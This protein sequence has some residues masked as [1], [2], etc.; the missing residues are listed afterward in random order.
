[1]KTAETA[2]KK[3]ELREKFLQYARAH[4]SGERIPTMAEFRKALGVTNYMLSG[5]MN[6]LVR[7]GF[8]VRKSR[9][10]GTFLSVAPKGKVIGLILEDGASNEYINQPGWMSGVCRAFC[11]AGDFH[12]RS[13]QLVR[14]ENLP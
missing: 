6:E 2:R 8:L 14:L 5:C 10:E 11:G 4:A 7:E 13:I 1:M 12:L 3:I 9:R